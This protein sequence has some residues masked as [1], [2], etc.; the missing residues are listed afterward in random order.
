MNFQERKTIEA[1]DLISTAQGNML[2]QGGKEWRRSDTPPNG[3]L[4]FLTVA[5]KKKMVPVI[6]KVMSSQSL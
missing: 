6:F 2:Q 4:I 1:G 5:F 3:I